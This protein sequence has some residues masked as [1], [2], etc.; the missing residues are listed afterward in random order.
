M[1]ASGKQHA[2][3]LGTGQTHYVA[4]RHDV[5]MSGLVRE[6]IDRAMT[7]AAVGWD[8]IDAVV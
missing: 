2:A 1:A 5:S 7:D 8:D 6:A 3:V 4:K